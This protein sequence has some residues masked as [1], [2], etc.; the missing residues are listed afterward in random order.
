MTLASVATFFGV[1]AQVIPA[2]LLAIIVDA[3]R[4]MARLWSISDARQRRP[5]YDDARASLITISAI[6]VGGIAE[7][8]SLFGVLYIKPSGDGVPAGSLILTGVVFVVIVVVLLILALLIPHFRRHFNII[9]RHL[10][11]YDVAR[12]KAWSLGYSTL[13]FGCLLLAGSDRAAES[14]TE[15][16]VS[17]LIAIPCVAT[18]LVVL[19]SSALGRP[20]LK[21]RRH[22]EEIDRSRWAGEER[23]EP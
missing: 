8:G 7:V 22:Y 10:S 16:F 23:P 15:E 19:I 14:K 9:G 18:G 12:I 1:A 20:L 4:G 17:L 6:I 5:S 11:S 2:I 21:S 13:I 3:S